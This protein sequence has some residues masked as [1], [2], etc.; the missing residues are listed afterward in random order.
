MTD[1]LTNLPAA[2]LSGVHPQCEFTGQSQVAVLK[3]TLPTG[4]Q[5]LWLLPVEPV[6]PDAPAKQTKH[7]NKI[8]NLTTFIK[9]NVILWK[10]CHSTGG[11]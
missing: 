10:G 2:D 1:E 7:Y 8:Q 6:D 4:P 11:L 5:E 3:P 9:I